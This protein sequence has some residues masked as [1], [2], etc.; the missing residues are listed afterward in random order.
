MSDQRRKFIVPLTV[1]VELDVEA[2]Q[3]RTLMSEDWQSSFY[4]FDHL[5]QALAYLARLNIMFDVGQE[6]FKYDA[7]A[8]DWIPEMAKELAHM[9]G[10]GDQRPGAMKAKVREAFQHD[11]DEV[12]EWDGTHWVF[13][14]VNE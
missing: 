7:E 1:E 6:V 2:E 4:Q 12:Q 3:L 14:A 9:D 10:H 5:E 13:G 8:R 11:Y